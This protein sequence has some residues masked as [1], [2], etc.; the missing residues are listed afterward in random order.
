ML[1]RDSWQVLRDLDE[2]EQWTERVQ[3]V[4]KADHSVYVSTA[5]EVVQDIIHA[6]MA[7]D[8]ST[9]PAMTAPAAATAPENTSVMS[10]D[11]FRDAQEEVRVVYE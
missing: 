2:A 9:V 8:E 4:T 11:D 10:T 1:L 3:V 5:Q 6:V 7:S